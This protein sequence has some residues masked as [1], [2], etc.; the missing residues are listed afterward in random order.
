M[1]FAASTGRTFGTS[2]GSRA[3]AVESD[4]LFLLFDD[5]LCAISS[6]DR[7]SRTTVLR[8]VLQPSDFAPR[9]VRNSQVYSIGYASQPTSSVVPANV[10]RFRRTTSLP[11]W[12]TIAPVSMLETGGIR[13]VGAPINPEGP[14][15]HG[16]ED[17][18]KLRLRVPACGDTGPPETI[19]TA[20]Y[21]IPTLHPLL[22][23]EERRAG[24]HRFR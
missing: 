3:P 20:G 18:R 13:R 16:P 5:F 8:A 22:L 6:L 21:L 10:A 2:T 24:T 14:C 23:L 11:R 9:K 19:V 1:S 4:D 7:P 12:M 17:A 15:P